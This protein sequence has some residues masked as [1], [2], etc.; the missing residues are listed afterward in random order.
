MQKLSLTLPGYGNIT[1]P[2]GLPGS[3]TPLSTIVNVFFGVLTVAAVILALF[4]LVSG[5]IDWITSG[6]DKQKIASARQKIT[7]SII[8]LV[9]V[10]LA[11]FIINIIYGFFG[12]GRPR[13]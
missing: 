7:F 4:F 10:F 13:V 2:G 11:F 8:G 12:V 5:G 3:S 1:P 6:G 9:L